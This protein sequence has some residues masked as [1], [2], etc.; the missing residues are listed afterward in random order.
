[1]ICD[2]ATYEPTDLAGCAGIQLLAEFDKLCALLSIDSDEQL[3][4]FLL[5]LG[6][7]HVCRCNVNCCLK[8]HSHRGLS[9]VA[10]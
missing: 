9:V 6:F 7:F 2:K 1:M 8:K 3:T 4:V 5:C 10:M